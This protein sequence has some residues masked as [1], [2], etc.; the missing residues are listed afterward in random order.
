MSSFLRDW[1]IFTTW[2]RLERKSFHIFLLQCD[3]STI[4]LSLGTCRRLPFHLPMKGE[5]ET[6]ANWGL[7]AG[8]RNSK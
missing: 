5:A 1:H 7:C 6:A 3:W 2:V 4:P 8:S